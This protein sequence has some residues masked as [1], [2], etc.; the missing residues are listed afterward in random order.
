M[1]DQVSVASKTKYIKIASATDR[2]T[3]TLSSFTVDLS[4]NSELQNCVAVQLLTAGFVN[5]TPNVTDE[6]NTVYIQLQDEKVVIPDGLAIR[7]QI[8]ESAIGVGGYPVWT[9]T[10]FI[11]GEYTPVEFAAHVETVINTV[12][13]TDH[14]I[15]VSV[16]RYYPYLRF[17]FSANVPIYTGDPLE[18]NEG[19]YLYGDPEIDT[20]AEYLGINQ[21]RL[22]FG[23]EPYGKNSPSKPTYEFIHQEFSQ[24][25]PQDNYNINELITALNNQSVPPEIVYEGVPFD[26]TWAYDPVLD[27]V[28]ASTTVDYPF[29][30]VKNVIEDRRST[31]SPILGYHGYESDGAYQTHIADS[32]TGLTGLYGAYLH[33]KPISTGM[34]CTVSKDNKQ[35]IEVSTIAGIPCAGVPYGTY[36]QTDFSKSGESYMIRFEE[37]RDISIL[38]VR[39]RTHQGELINTAAPG[40]TMTLKCFLR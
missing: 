6:T 11:A 16:E 14:S 28:V 24:T 19:I 36:T 22:L 29:F 38:Q 12:I 35:G 30:R 15:N 4:A 40:V 23:T 1:S 13:V 27:R 10:G 5:L 31:L 34:T 17:R 33:L 20:L 32:P 25:I 2:T 8:K 9:A 3:G 26:L 39:L 21:F 18:G 37:Q 7:V